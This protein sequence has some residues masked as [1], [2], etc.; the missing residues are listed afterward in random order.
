MKI[1]MN[2]YNAAIE[3]IIYRKI[4]GIDCTEQ[5]SAEIKQEIKNNCNYNKKIVSLFPIEYSEAIDELFNDN[6]PIEGKQ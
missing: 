4:D 2:R 1:L 3:A 5:E 6:N